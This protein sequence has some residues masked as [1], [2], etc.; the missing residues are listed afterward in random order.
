MNM[1]YKLCYLT[2]ENGHLYE[3]N[4]SW[5]NFRNKG[6]VDIATGVKVSKNTDNTNIKN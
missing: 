4:L 6:A 1:Y 5:N 3:L 2:G